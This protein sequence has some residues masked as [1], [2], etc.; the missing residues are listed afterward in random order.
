VKTADNRPS[1]RRPAIHSGV[2]DPLF[3]G[4]GS[5]SC[6]N[7]RPA[8]AIIF[9]RR[10]RHGV[11]V[12]ENRFRHGGCFPRTGSYCRESDKDQLSHAGSV[13]RT[14]V[15]AASWG[16]LFQM[17]VARLPQ[18]INQQTGCDD[19]DC[20]LTRKPAARRPA[21]S[22]PSVGVSPRVRGRRSPTRPGPR[23]VLGDRRP[24]ESAASSAAFHEP[25]FDLSQRPPTS[26]AES[27]AS[28]ELDSNEIPTATL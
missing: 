18:A 6:V 17:G 26:R 5:I 7:L 13:V 23:S 12:S 20:W 3:S 10:V 19:A 4:F 27:P 9:A 28:S 22:R 11:I 15:S 14:G 16:C 2:H 25:D 21:R 8:M 24:T 1:G